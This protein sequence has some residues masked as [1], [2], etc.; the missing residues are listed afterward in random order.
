MYKNNVFLAIRLLEVD[1]RAEFSRMSK[2]FTTLAGLPTTIDLSSID[3]VTTLSAP[4]IQ[5]SPI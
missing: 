5:F 4:I 2:L 3:L 1:N